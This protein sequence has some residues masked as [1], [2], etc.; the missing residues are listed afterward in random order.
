MSLFAKSIC[1]DFPRAGKNSNVFTAVHPLDFELCP[2][3][4]IEITGRSG[5]GKS[6][7]LNMLSGMLK[8]TSGRILL[9]ETDIYALK[10]NALARLRNEK[11]GFVPQGHTALLGLTVTENV[12]LP[13]ILYGKNPP[14]V[15]RAEE[16]LKEVGLSAML[17]ARPNELSGGELRRMAIAR[18]L[19]MDPPFLLADEPTAGLAE[20]NIFIVLRL[21]RK[22]A[23]RGTAVLFVTHENEAAQ[24]ADEVRT[25]EGGRFV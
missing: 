3:K 15:Q 9:D 14:P 12:L 18:A 24:F 11:I 17:T 20:E 25:M 1:K 4:M 10:E 13:S 6:T 21:L 7:L 16:L 19:L 23:D 5:S 22:A 2:G 8:P